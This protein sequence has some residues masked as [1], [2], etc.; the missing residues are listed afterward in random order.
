MRLPRLL[1]RKS[2]PGFILGGEDVYLLRYPLLRLKRRCVGVCTSPLFTSYHSGGKFRNRLVFIIVRHMVL[3][4][5][6]WSLQ[7]NK[8][9]SSGMEKIGFGTKMRLMPSSF[10]FFCRNGDAIPSNV[11]GRASVKR[12]VSQSVKAVRQRISICLDGSSPIPARKTPLFY[13]M[14]CVLLRAAC[15]HHSAGTA[16]QQRQQ[17]QQQQTEAGIEKTASSQ[18]KLPAPKKTGFT[19]S[20]RR[21]P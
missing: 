21:F 15:K 8:Q 16:Q 19:Y 5:P 20:A 3:T 17:Q 10:C 4:F 9:F 13:F 1:W 11:R 7:H 12:S 14:F 6:F 2:D 18:Y